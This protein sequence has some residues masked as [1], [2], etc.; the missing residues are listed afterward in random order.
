ML[1]APLVYVGPTTDAALPNV[2]VKGKIA[3]QHLKPASGAYSER[4]R[5]VERAR[6]LTKRG[7]VAVL[8]VVEQTGNM[9]VRDFGN[10]GAPCFNLGGADGK[11][12]EAA[13]Q[14]A[15]AA[16]QGRPCACNCGSRPR[17]MTGLKGQ[18]AMG[19][20]PR[21]I[22]RGRREHHRQCPR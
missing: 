3:V 16:E 4:T 20:V 5:T 14:K 22:R 7:A 13:I 12:V 8:N 19:V 6:E 10:C 17:C 15:G 2:D 18:N 1:S 11:F 21:P 9:H